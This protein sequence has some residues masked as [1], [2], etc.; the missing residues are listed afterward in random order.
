MQK[1]RSYAAAGKASAAI[2][3]ALEAVRKHWIHKELTG[4]AGGPPATPAARPRQGATP[5]TSTPGA[6][7]GSVRS[8]SGTLGTGAASPKSPA[9][10]GVTTGPALQGAAGSSSAGDGG[11]A[12]GGSEAAATP[13]GA[14]GLAA[15][16][17]NNNVSRIFSGRGK[18][19][20]RIGE[21]EGVLDDDGSIEEE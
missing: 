17:T 9:G 20:D 3:A 14:T 11:S 13:A 18:Q 12:A 1:L 6:A 2:D 5:A 19:L 8:N 21:A 10:G 7:A 15:R 16:L 4:S